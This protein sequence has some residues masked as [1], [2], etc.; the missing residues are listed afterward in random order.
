MNSLSV[1]V[2]GHTNVG[3]TSLIRTLLRDVNFGEVQDTAGTTRVV[4]GASLNI[5]NSGALSLFDTPGLEDSIHL[6][7][8]LNEVPGSNVEGIDRLHYFLS[9]LDDSPELAQ[10]A[11][12]LRALLNNDLIFY[13]ID[14]RSSVL[15]KFRDELKILSYAAKPVIPVLNF[16]KAG[17]DN[18]DEW[19][20]QLARLNFH[21]TVAFDS[22]RFKF[23]DELKIYQKMQTL[24]MDKEAFLESLILQRQ[25]QWQQT[26]KIAQEKVANLFINC[27][28]LRLLSDNEEKSIQ[29]NTQKLQFK[30]RKAES[31]CIAE[32]LTL[33]QFRQS[34]LNEQQLNI[35]EGEWALDLFSLE[36]LQEFGVETGGY[37]AKGAG[38][39]VVIDLAVG[40][41]TLGAA[42]ATGG[43][44]GA[45]WGVKERY[46]N[47]IE[48]SLRGSR[49]ICLNDETLQVLWLRQLSLL[50]VLQQ[51]GHASLTA[52]E[53]R[54]SKAVENE[55]P[56]AW[57][58]ALKRIR[59]YPQW[60]SLTKNKGRTY[61]EKRVETLQKLISTFEM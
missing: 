48:A 19:K 46:Y 29:E 37:I 55:L 56:K 25:Q 58:S 24:L 12:V 59:R 61:S 36:L 7:H 34:D 50:K 40:G 49:Y 27:A 51:R 9:H 38:V 5:E 20:L 53:Y 13:V 32:L 3:K 45:M 54:Q 23:S 14:L 8:I 41:I 10:E 4:E 31:K 30:I 11:K 39:G 57:F 26:L 60:S 22:I 16:L 33:Y 6:L 47:E 15:S 18:L 28:G 52:I 43:L 1:A 44:I 21:A 2:V 42:A 17:A 35:K